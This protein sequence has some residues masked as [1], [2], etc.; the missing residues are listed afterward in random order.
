M[1]MPVEGVMRRFSVG[2]I[3]TPQPGQATMGHPASE[4]IGIGSSE[5]MDCN[6]SN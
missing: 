3:E 1:T 2:R 4:I 6:Y 5:A